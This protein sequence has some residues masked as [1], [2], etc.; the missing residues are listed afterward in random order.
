MTTAHGPNEYWQ[1]RAA[2]ID[3]IVESWRAGVAFAMTALKSAILLN[4]AAAVAILAFLGHASTSEKSGNTLAEIHLTLLTISLRNF[5]IGA[6]SAVVAT[7]I[8]YLSSYAENRSL[9]AWV[10]SSPWAPKFDWAG[11]A[12]QFVAVIT[13][14]YAYF[15]FWQGMDAGI[16]ALGPK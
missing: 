3:E 4:G 1:R 9:W 10:R 12:L 11:R 7:A 6:F 2:R 16:L 5:L 15:R 13:V 14:G 8:A